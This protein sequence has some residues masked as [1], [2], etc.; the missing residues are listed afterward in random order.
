MPNRV[1]WFQRTFSSDFPADHFPE[2]IERLRGT[3]ARIAFLTRD[4]PAPTLARRE[5]DTWSIQENVGHL[6]D[7]EALFSGR[8]DDFEAALPAL[9]AADLTN[10]RTHEAGHNNTP[11]AGVLGAFSD[12]RA[13][14]VARLEAFPPEFFAR[15]AHHPRLNKPMRVVDSM[16]FQAE[17]DDCHLARIR[18]LVRAFTGR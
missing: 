3:P 5:G 2:I 9:R 6:T 13:A 16:F 1:P 8:I 7:L 18:E 11:F 12:A 14:F 15:V 4:L 10:R 17:H